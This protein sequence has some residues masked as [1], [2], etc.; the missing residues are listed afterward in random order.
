MELRTIVIADPNVWLREGIHSV[1]TDEGYEVV[2]E[3]GNGRDALAQISERKPDLVLIDSTLPCTDAV[4]AIHRM[5]DVS[6][7]TRTLVLMDLEAP[8]LITEL[9]EAGAGGCILKSEPKEELLTALKAMA[10]GELYLSPKMNTRIGDIVA[11]RNGMRAPIEGRLREVLHGVA[12]GKT[13][14]EIAACLGLSVRTVEAHRHRL[15]E[16][17]GMHSTAELVRYAVREGLVSP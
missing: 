3:A 11:R 7:E 15:M 16:R 2:G 8:M 4:E 17:L 12:E 13:N 5:R 9:M 10:N 1:L 6:P 14:K